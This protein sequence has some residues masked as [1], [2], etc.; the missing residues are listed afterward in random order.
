MNKQQ[1]L[2]QQLK[3]LLSNNTLPPLCFNA[4]ETRDL[5]KA[6]KEQLSCK[7]TCHFSTPDCKECKKDPAPQEKQKKYWCPACEEYENVKD[8]GDICCSVCGIIITS[9]E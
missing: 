4:S 8:D 6:Y 9:Y 7:H 2:E 5:L 3:L 1:L